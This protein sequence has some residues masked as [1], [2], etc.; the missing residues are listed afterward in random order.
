[1]SSLPKESE[2]LVF[3][4][5]EFVAEKLARVSPLDRGFLYGDGVFET[6]RVANG[7]PFLWESHMRR[8][9]L[10]IRYP[11]ISGRFDS[12]QIERETKTLL[13]ENRVTDGFLRIQVTRGAGARG[14]SPRGASSPTLVITTHPASA[15]SPARLK[16]MTSKIRLIADEPWTQ[17]KTTNRLPNILARAEVDEA[18][19]DEALLLNHRWTIAGASAANLF[20]VRKDSLLTPPLA[21]GGIAGT[22]RAFIIQSA[23]NL[24]MD[25]R[26]EE[27][28]LEDFYASEA[29]FL[30]SAGLLVTPVESLD[31]KPINP[32]HAAIEKLSAI[33]Q[34]ALHQK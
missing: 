26:E 13:L 24:G 20:C 31:S 34:Q 14:Y 19:M 3:I 17:L 7:H 10:G 5:G 9:E 22:T 18:G 16:L 1:V 30:T 33:C 29:A 8:L 12:A 27:L 6:I 4:N 28:S 25:V 15:A 32:G 23:R 2:S 21:A 11:K